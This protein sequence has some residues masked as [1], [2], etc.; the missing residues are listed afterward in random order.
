MAAKQEALKRPEDFLPE[1][2]ELACTAR[3][4]TLATAADGQPLASLVTPAFLPSGEPLL[5]LSSLAV[6]TR[7]L[8]ANPA[9]CLLLAGPA[10]TENPQTAPRLALSGHA[11]PSDDPAAKE[12]FLITHPYAALY[13][14]FTD[15]GFWRVI[16]SKA[17]Y[18]GG[19]AASFHLNAAA[20]QHEI[21]RLLAQR[22]V[23]AP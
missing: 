9:C 4:A 19:F 2:A 13:A 6:H 18:I 14:D 17:Q 23:D 8:R 7:Q 3:V 1:A 20:L 11:E 21:I 10:A 12:V 22:T 5:L 15:F 16:V